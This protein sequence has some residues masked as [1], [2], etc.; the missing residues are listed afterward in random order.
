MCNALATAFLG[1]I[2]RPKNDD[3]SD[4]SLGPILDNY[5][6]VKANSLIQA[7]DNAA[8]R[9]MEEKIRVACTPE[10]DNDVKPAADDLRVAVGKMEPVMRQVITEALSKEGRTL[11]WVRVMTAG[12]MQFSKVYQSV[13]EY[14][15]ENEEDGIKQY[16]AVIDRVR[17][18]LPGGKAPLQRP[19]NLVDLYVEAARTQPGFKKVMNRVQQ[20]YHERTHHELK[21][22][23][24]QKLK[25]VTRILEKMIMRGSVR[26][27]KD[28]VRAMATVNSMGEV[29]TVGKVM[30]EL[31]T[32][33]DKVIKLL[34]IKER[35]FQQPSSGGWRGEYR[36]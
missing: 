14:I 21:L 30:L 3:H 15:E 24:C 4:I 12:D 13:F 9:L 11:E 5:E 23:V 2:P 33:K 16:H 28:I 6:P 7:H 34:R 20:M 22:S 25:K 31:H 10:D 17:Q 26:G 35:F 32:H 8:L 1:Q 18:V 29:G 27:V 36:R 19:D